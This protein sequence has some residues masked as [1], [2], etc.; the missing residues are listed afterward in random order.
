MKTTQLKSIVLAAIT[1]T[2]ALAITGCVTT[3]SSGYKQADKT[4]KGMAEF[5]DEVVKAQT[6]INNTV[7][8]LDAVAQTAA[9]DPRKSYEQFS[10]NVDQ[11][12]SAAAKLSKRSQDMQASGDAYFKQWEAQMA[13]VQSPDIKALA[14]KRR[15]ELQEAFAN[16]KTVATPLKAQFDPWM[17]ELKDL[18]SYLGQDLTVAGVNAAKK[19]IAKAQK[20]G[21]AVKQSMDSLVAELNSVAAALTPAKVVPPKEEPAKK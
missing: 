2:A 11:L 21:V 18:R 16:I 9:T 13:E 12:E 8:S 5:R 4:G 17:V 7:A 15:A 6:A 3:G 1:A 14:E 20:D 19:P 10:K